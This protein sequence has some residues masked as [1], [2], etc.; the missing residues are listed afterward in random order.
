MIPTRSRFPGL[1]CLIPALAAALAGSGACSRRE[2]AAPPDARRPALRSEQELAAERDQR[3]ASGQVAPESQPAFVAAE[4][5]KIAQIESAAAKPRPGEVTAD[6]L[7]VDDE[8]ITTAEVLYALRDRIEEARRT[9]TRGGFQEQLARMIRRETQERVGRA[10]LYRKAIAPLSE[11]A[12]ENITRAVDREFD[13]ELARDFA[14]SRARMDIQLRR[15]GLSIDQYRAGIERRLV[16]QQYLFETMRPTMHVRRDELLEEYRRQLPRFTTSELRELFIIEAPFERFL[17]SGG[18]WGQASPQQQAAARVR[19]TQHIRAAHEALAS[20]P[21]EEVA[22]R[23][24][25]GLHADEGGAWG[26]I[27]RP[28]TGAYEPLSA[29][30]FQFEPGQVSEP[31]ETPAGWYIVRCGAVRAGRIVPFEEAQGPLR[32]EMADARF[33]VAATDYVLRLAARATLTS[34]EAFIREAIR[35]AAAPGWPDAPAP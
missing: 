34:S 18:S 30:I 25:R 1:C 17:T 10:L 23:M 33:N 32:Q 15:Y 28:L 7:L 14:G 20:E 3:I 5:S 27:G 21:F 26:A 8:V 16:V 19:A 31:V 24:S 9:Q 2:P 11:P 12:K 22:R 4:S 13:E 35:R 29:L 6:V